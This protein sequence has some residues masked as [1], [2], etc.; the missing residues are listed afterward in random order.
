VGD[1]VA[2]LQGLSVGE[3]VLA[4]PTDKTSDGLAVVE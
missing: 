3:H 1:Q 2:V 4:R